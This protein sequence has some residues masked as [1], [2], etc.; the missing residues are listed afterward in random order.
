MRLP[1]HEVWYEGFPINGNV[2]FALL[3]DLHHGLTA[4]THKNIEDLFKALQIKLKGSNTCFIFAGDQI[5]CKQENH[6][7]LFRLFREKFPDHT[8]YPAVFCGGN[9][10]MWDS[11]QRHGKLIPYPISYEE[12][13]ENRKKIAD[14]FHLHDVQNGIFEAPNNI[15]VVG[16]DSW[17]WHLSPRTNDKTFMA[18]QYCEQDAFVFLN[19]KAHSDLDKILQLDLSKYRKK[20]CVTHFPP[21]TDNIK[22]HEFNA[23][24]NFMEPITKNFD[25]LCVGHS[26][27]KA[28][29]FENGCH[30]LNCGS[31]SGLDKNE[32]IRECPRAVL[33]TI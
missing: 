4:N 16:F 1:K 2:G 21:F 31:E 17:Y 30:V 9:H 12:L 28:N 25:V 14:T 20:I 6:F 3:S 19:K 33:F 11:Y 23:S 29:F 18:M 24:H 13:I 8:Q 15:A 7:K 5:S 27:K 10:D 32:K 26:H 22:Y